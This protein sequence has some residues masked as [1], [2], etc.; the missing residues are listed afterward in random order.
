MKNQKKKDMKVLSKVTASEQESID[1]SYLS[2][3]CLSQST[4]L[5][6]LQLPPSQKVETKV[7]KSTIAFA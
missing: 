3:L 2:Y 6:Y 4:V 5:G 7:E 1:F